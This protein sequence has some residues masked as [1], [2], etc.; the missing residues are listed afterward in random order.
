MPDSNRLLTRVSRLDVEG[1][2]LRPHGQRVFGLKSFASLLSRA[3]LVFSFL[4]FPAAAQDE[5]SDGIEI[6][7]PTIAIARALDKIT[8][9]ITELEL[10]EGEM[11]K[12]GTLEITA[13]TCRQRPPEEPP[14]TFVFLEI[15]DRKSDSEQERIFTGWM[16][17]SS[18]ALN[19]L[20]HPVYD[21]WVI[22]CKISEPATVSFNR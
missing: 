19:A 10:P 6:R 11:V 20:E 5:K 7:Q 15:D 13:R 1:M 4:F 2:T 18:P 3:L 16:M 21:V 22:D 17:A 14:E 9:Q 12:F 8:A